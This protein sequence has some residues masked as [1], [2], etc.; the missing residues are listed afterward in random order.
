MCI[1]C[2]DEIMLPLFFISFEIGYCAV[3]N[4]YLGKVSYDRK[5][6]CAEN[7]NFTG[8]P[9]KQYRSNE[10]FL[11]KD[12]N[13]HELVLFLYYLDNLIHSI[14]LKLFIYVHIKNMKPYIFQIYFDL[15][16]SLSC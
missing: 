11:C 4:T 3:Y 2:G 15:S 7:K 8:C 5:T 9:E 10:T 16:L 6:N 13:L 12:F 1:N 14:N